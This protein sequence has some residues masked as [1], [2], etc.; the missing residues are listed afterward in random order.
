MNDI[1]N[2]T[3]AILVVLAIIVSLVGLFIGR[4][5]IVTIGEGATLPE[6]DT[7]LIQASVQADLEIWAEGDIDFGN[8]DAGGPAVNSEDLGPSYIRVA[9]VG[10]TPADISYWTAPTP[11]YPDYG[12]LLFDNLLATGLQNSGKVPD[13]SFQFHL[14]SAA[15]NTITVGPNTGIM[16]NCAGTY[17]PALGGA[18]QQI[19]ALLAASILFGE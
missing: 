9:S 3:L 5:K 10:G 4:T 15:G 7:G 1:S 19:A 12:G 8:Q 11:T 16:S 6:Q 13:N 18:Y 14:V 17:T 2:K